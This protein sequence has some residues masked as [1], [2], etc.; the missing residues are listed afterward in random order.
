MTSNVTRTT[1]CTHTAAELQLQ[2][3][4]RLTNSAAAATAPHQ[5]R[6]RALCQAPYAALRV[7]LGPLVDLDPLQTDQDDV[8]LRWL[9]SAHNLL[10]ATRK[11][12]PAD[13]YHA[14]T[15]DLA[16]VGAFMPKGKPT[17]HVNGPRPMGTGEEARTEEALAKWIVLPYVPCADQVR[18]HMMFWAD[19]AGLVRYPQTGAAPSQQPIWLA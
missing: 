1:P 8:L 15:A 4:V 16:P 11:M 2:S 9:D 14:A 18:S 17:V 10:S 12:I 5:R 7:V 3:K 6:R 13:I 19:D